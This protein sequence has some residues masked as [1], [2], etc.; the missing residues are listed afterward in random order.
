MRCPRRSLPRLHLQQ[1]HVRFDRFTQWAGHYSTL[2]ANDGQADSNLTT[3]SIA[4]NPVNDPPVLAT[5]GDKTIAED[6]LLA[7]NLSASDP[8][9]DVLTF[10]VT[11]LPEG[12][13]LDSATGAFSWTPSFEQAGSYTVTFTVTDPR[14]LSASE[15]ITITVEDVIINQGPVCSAARP[16]IEEIWPPNHERTE[17]VEILGVTDPDNDPLTL[18]IL[19]ILQDEPTNTW[20]DGTTWVDGGGIGTARAWVRAERSGAKRVAGNGRV[21]DLLRSQ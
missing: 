7:F 20:G 21:Y 17:L 10:S 9:G 14:G 16:S 19:R 11:G 8:D 13:T 6:A 4:V 12:A 1:R 15:T 2:V 3:V 18:V 5:V